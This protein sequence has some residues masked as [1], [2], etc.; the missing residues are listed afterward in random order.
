MHGFGVLCWILWQRRNKV[1]LNK[2]MDRVEHTNAFVGGHLD[3]FLQCNSRGEPPPKP[4]HQIRWTTPTQY[5]YKFNYDDAVFQDKGEVG[6]GVVVL[7]A[8]GLPMASLVQ[9]IK[10]PMSVEAV[11]ALA[12][13]RAIQFALEIGIREGN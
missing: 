8:R 13:K 12:A 11:E 3:E 7:D 6:L 4:C 5:R 10:Y 9:R 2:P 1:R